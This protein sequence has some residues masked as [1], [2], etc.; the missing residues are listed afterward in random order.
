[1]IYPVEHCHYRR[2]DC[3]LTVAEVNKERSKGKDTDIRTE[4]DYTILYIKIYT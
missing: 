2:G 4:V 3:W 1:M